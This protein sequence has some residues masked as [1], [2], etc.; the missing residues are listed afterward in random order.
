MLIFLYY[1]VIQ[2]KTS[3]YVFQLN[4]NIY[5]YLVKAFKPDDIIAKC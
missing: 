2:S 3:L 1:V 5:L 4:F